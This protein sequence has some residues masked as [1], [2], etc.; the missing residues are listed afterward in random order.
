MEGYRANWIPYSMAME[1]IMPRHYAGRKPQISWAFGLFDDKENNMVA[2]CTFGKPASASLCKGVCGENN[3]KKVIELNR[4]VCDGELK[5]NALS[6]FV[7]WC[8][9]QLKDDD[10]IVVSYSDTGMGH[11]GYIYQA[12]NFIY[13]GVTKERTDKYTEG[14]KH[15][16]HYDDQ[17]NHLRK[18]R[19]AK[20]RYVFFTGKSKKKY[21]KELKYPIH[22]YPKGDNDYYK[23]GDRQK[24]KIL[25][26]KEGKEFWQ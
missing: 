24:T 12:T 2:C 15:S 26:T 16:R 25:N 23:L 22:P 1:F 10:L 19:T 14:N 11:H 4:L 20:H 18:V 5:K 6:F 21:F 9:R 7:G 17:F 3:H 13:T 8:L